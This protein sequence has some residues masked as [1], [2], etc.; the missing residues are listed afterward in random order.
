MKVGDILICKKTINNV[1]RLPL[2]I[3]NHEYRILHI[4]DQYDE[5]YLEHILYSNEYSSFPRKTIEENFVSLKD[6]RKEKLNNIN[7]N[8]ETFNE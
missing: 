8:N 3:V 4:D 2:F 7:N 1:F 5:I 6:L